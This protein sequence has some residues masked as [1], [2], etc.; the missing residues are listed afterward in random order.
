VTGGASRAALRRGAAVAGRGVVGF[1][2][3]TAVYYLLRGAGAAVYPALVVSAVVSAGP[4][5]VQLARRRRVD[6]L[7]AYAS[8]M[9]VGALAVSLVPGDTRLLL[10]KDAVLTGVTGAWFLMSARGDRPLAYLFTRPI[11]QGRFRWPADWDGLWE[12]S[13]GFRRMWRVSSVLWGTA[14]LF[15][16][17][18]RVVMA[19]RL[20]PDRVPALAL[21]LYVAVTVVLVVVTNVYYVL[22]G[23]HDP[24]SPLRDP[25]GRGRLPVRLRA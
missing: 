8:A 24:R 14:L 20:P 9:T 4:G 13:P 17:G 19:Y 1:V 7:S 11:V 25:P 5:A 6:G 18:L 22:C 16:A 3:P 2:L 15:D 23:V 12:R 10:A 21:A